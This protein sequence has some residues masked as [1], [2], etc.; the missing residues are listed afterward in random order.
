[1]KLQAYLSSDK[2]TAKAMEARYAYV[3]AQA[4]S[5]RQKN[6]TPEEL[7]ETVALE[8]FKA[9]VQFQGRIA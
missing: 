1:M 6:L 7:C 9:R 8:N 3:Y 4:I 2:V 5:E